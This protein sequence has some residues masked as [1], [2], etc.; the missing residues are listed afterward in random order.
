MTDPL[1]IAGCTRDERYVEVE[2]GVQLR[3]LGWRPVE[4]SGAS[5]VL[6][7]AGWVSAVEGWLDL[8]R[9]LAPRRPVYYLETRE[10]LSAR[11]AQG[12]KLTAARF[13]VDRM[14]QDIAA[15]ARELGLPKDAVAMG[16]SLGSTSILEAMKGGRLPV[17]AAFLIGANVR[18][19]YP[20]WAPA[21]IHLPAPAYHLVKHPILFYLRHFRVDAKREPEQMARYR[22]TLLT[23]EP[24]R[25]KLSALAFQGYEIWPGLE[26]VERPVAIAFA[27]SD[28]LHGQ[29]DQDRLVA[30]LKRGTG[31]EC[32]SNKYLHS[33]ALT[34]EFERYLAGL[35]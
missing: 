22:A 27:H 20:W 24:H 12:Q 30:G 21:V 35:E 25:I 29:Q 17:R 16:S 34:E 26:T 6:F 5:P 15:A 23:A 14:A 18:F 2:P 7:V 3:V 11:F 9:A 10:K 32:P 33:G 31:V 13:G 4:P 19:R 8:L 1:E 28:S